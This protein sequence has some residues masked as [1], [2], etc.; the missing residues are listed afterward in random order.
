LI[1]VDSELTSEVLILEK[2]ND[3]GFL[4]IKLSFHGSSIY[5]TCSY[6]PSSFELPIYANHLSPIQTI[7]NK[8][9]DRDLLIVLRD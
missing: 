5:I 3:I 4:V 8:L 6:I 9:S 2:R 1:V 7:S